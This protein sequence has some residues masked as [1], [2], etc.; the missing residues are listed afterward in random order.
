MIQPTPRPLADPATAA[1]SGGM[2]DAHAAAHSNGAA[3]PNAEP[4]T[5][6]AEAAGTGA[7]AAGTGATD[8]K[9]VQQ[10]WIEA[11]RSIWHELPGLVSDR[12]DL[13]ALE[14][15][16]AGR[17]LAQMVA[18]VVAAAILGV[19]AWLAL[20]AGI[21]VGLVELGLHWS[22]SLLLVLA[23][24]AVTAVLA[25]MRLRSLLPL[26]RLPATRRH[27][28]P[29]RT[30]EPTTPPSGTGTGMGTGTGTQ[31]AATGNT[32]PLGQAG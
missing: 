24:N 25:V 20:W 11:L 7:E 15:Q 3:A 14:V 23:L 5:G 4:P 30:T 8:R 16:R 26:L 1:R 12:V 21:A 9:A 17:A 19:T 13:L 27:L 18:M 10:G 28:A 2:A 22:L 29:G 32:P 31:N 6:S